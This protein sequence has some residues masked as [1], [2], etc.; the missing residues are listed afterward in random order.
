M[1]L[2][3]L[4]ALTLTAVLG[5]TASPASGSTSSADSM[6][7]HILARM[8]RDRA[9]RGLVRYRGWS[10]VSSLATDRAQSM[11][12]V[13]TLSHDAAGGDL[14][15]ALTADGVQWFAFGEIIGTANAPWGREVADYIYKL[16]KHSS[17]HAALMFSR[18]YNYVGIG[19]AHNARTGSTYASVVFVDS[20]DHTR[21]V[22]HN[23]KLSRSGRT[24]T[25][26]W[27][28]H[29]RRLQTR[30]AGLRSFD[31]QMRR[32]SGTWRTIRNDVT[33]TRLTL[34]HR[35]RGHWFWFRVQSKDRR[36][37]LSR[38]STPVRVWV[39]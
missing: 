21:P 34:R 13:N 16:W 38:W 36:G 11:A 35:A 22:A 31:V 15:K 24:I 26:R 19:F 4:A 27:S 14:G 32:D 9:A 2:V 30:T 8:N 12:S 28:G 25:F 5:S 33:R 39:G 17:Y 29:D 20:R 1:A 7:R 37:N 6:A 10:P 3:L 23:G 18:S